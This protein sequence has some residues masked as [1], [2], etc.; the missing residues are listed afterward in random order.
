MRLSLLSIS[1]LF[2]FVAAGSAACAQGTQNVVPPTTYEEC[3]TQ[4]GKVLKSYPPRCVTDQ[5]IVFVDQRAELAGGKACKD[6]CGDG[7]CQEIVCM[8]VGCPCA[9]SPA[10]CPKDCA[11]Q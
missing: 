11:K 8:A 6:L 4:R 3:V 10:S 2:F 1:S 9:E 5:G 7:V